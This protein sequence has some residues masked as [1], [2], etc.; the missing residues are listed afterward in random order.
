M[1]MLDIMRALTG[2]GGGGLVTLATIVNS[3]IIAPEQRGNWQAFQNVLFG[4]GSICGASFGGTI[5]QTFGWRWC[6]VLQAPIGFTG[7]IS[8][9]LFVKN[10]EKNSKDLL[11]SDPDDDDSID[12]IIVDDSRSLDKIDFKGSITL[13]LA[14]SLQALVLSLGGNQVAWSDYRLILVLLLSCAF[15]VKFALVEMNTT[16]LPII[17]PT[18]LHGTFTYFI[19]GIGVLVGISGF[20]YLFILPMLFQIILGDSVS[21]AGLRL[22]IPSL[23]T[24]VGGLITG[25]TMSRG[26]NNLFKLV[27]CGAFLMFLGNFLALQI[28]KGEN[29]WLVGLFLIPANVGQGMICP[30]SLFAFIYIFDKDKQAI[31]TSTAYLFRSVGSIWGVSGSSTIIRHVLRR[32]AAKSLIDVPGMTSKR[33]ERIINQVSRDISSAKRLDPAI[34][35]LIHEAYVVAIREAQ[36]FS[37]LFCFLCLGVCLMKVA[38]GV[39]SRSSYSDIDEPVLK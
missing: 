20:A 33:I 13:V 30:S 39:K 10:P 7:I 38:M 19:L 28:D 35:E 34:Y 22:T 37:C 12:R 26:G 14:L 8:A 29:A 16:A 15:L 17:P 3:D 6:F 32:V 1:I 36:M 9:Y 31:A 25:F 11:T 18:L 23:F 5:A 21:Q 27:T 2:I 24:P 4:F